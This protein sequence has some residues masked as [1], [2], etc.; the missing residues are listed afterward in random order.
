MKELDRFATEYKKDMQISTKLLGMIGG[1]VVIGCA[2][3]ATMTMLIFNQGIIKDTQE[4]L[5]YTIKGVNYTLKD[6]AKTLSATGGIIAENSDIQIAAKI[7]DENMLRTVV[8]TQGESTGFDFFAISDSNGV[9]INGASYNCGAGN[10]S[11][12][13]VVK[14]AL[15]TKRSIWGIEEFSN[16]SYAIVS[17]SPIKLGAELVGTVICGY[18]L[19]RP[20]FPDLINSQYGV[21]CT[22]FKGD[23]RISTTILDE[24]GNRAVGTKLGNPEI[25]DTIFNKNER[26]AGNNKILGENYTSIYQPLTSVDNKVTGVV[27]V[28][29]SMKIVQHIRDN[30]IKTV[31][32]GAILL[33]VI[34]IGS[35]LFF[36][37]WL[38]WRIR[39]VTNSLEDMA[40]G[41]AD[42]TKRCKLFIR[43]EIG[44]LVI[45][46]DA[47]C[48]RL[49]NIIREIKGSKDELKDVGENLSAQTEDTS[50]AID[51]IISNIES[52]H[53]Q[54]FNS[55][56]CVQQTSSAVN[57]ISQSISSLDEMIDSQS[58]GVSQASAAVEEMIGN[59]TSVN[60]SVDKMAA[61]FD[62]L[63]ANAQTGFSKQQDVNERIEQIES[64]SQ[65]L[66]EANLAISTIAAQTNLLAMNAAIEAAHAGEAGKGFSVVADEIRKLSETSSAQSK[67]IG[68]QLKKIKDS[69]SEVVSASAESSA[70]FSSVSDKIKETDQLVIQ[71]KAAM[72]EQ[73]EGSKQISETLKAMNDSTVEVHKASKDMAAKSDLILKEMQTLQDSSEEMK[74]GME[75]MADGARKIHETGLSLGDISKQVQG[76]ID[77]IG[78]QIDLFIV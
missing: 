73:N 72:E 8:R 17:A 30:T 18:D 53:K 6:W 40:T 13:S 71:I 55:S 32:P 5:E 43:D 39:N 78:S 27:F 1:A 60:H 58:A 29:K 67:T 23:E 24:K 28:A 41:E 20:Q 49:Q 70:A 51:Q 16:V 59:I 57:E 9:I 19:S 14:K 77:K 3:V 21:A 74:S 68:E 36:I 44:F 65:M 42:L 64:Q 62:S 54:I 31:L 56:Q 10:V 37:N 48:D 2:A 11:N 47:F 35:S 38:M 25:E 12:C 45:K 63:A 4:N 75:S 34:L 66:Q 52:I 22:I 33:A 26:Y 76:S 46:F 69:I 7:Q 50:N 61:S 15:S